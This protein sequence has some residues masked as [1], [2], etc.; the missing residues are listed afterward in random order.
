MTA[1]D[2]R[3]QWQAIIDD[4]KR[5][6]G[7]DPNKMIGCL[8]EKVAQERREAALVKAELRALKLKL[9]AQ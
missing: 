7:G 4:A 9:E 5:T 2:R 3:A 6:T 8:A 1:Q